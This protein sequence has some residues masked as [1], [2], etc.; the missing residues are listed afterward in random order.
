MESKNVRFLLG[1]G[2]GSVLGMVLYRCSKTEK[3]KEL[4]EKVC[5]KMKSM[6]EQAGEWMCN[7]PE[8]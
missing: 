8:K 4:K 2:I 3:A 7:V 5:N 6:G 1:L